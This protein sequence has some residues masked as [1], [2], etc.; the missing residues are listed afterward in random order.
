MSEHGHIT[1]DLSGIDWIGD[2]YR[3]QVTEDS[4][5]VDEMQAARSVAERTP[6]RWLVYVVHARGDRPWSVY[7]F[8]DRDEADECLIEEHTAICFDEQLDELVA[9]RMVDRCFLVDGRGVW[10]VEQDGEGGH[11]LPRDRRE[12]AT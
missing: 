12:E 9:E 11:A 1:A 6:C 5:Y 8:S 7:A 4:P 10:V 3:V 2:G